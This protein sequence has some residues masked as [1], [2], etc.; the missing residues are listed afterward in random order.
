ML[1]MPAEKQEIDKEPWTGR[2]TEVRIG[3]ER[4]KDKSISQRRN[5]VTVSKCA[6]RSSN[7]R[8]GKYPLNPIV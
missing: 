6:E 5:W 1:G 2:E 7:M 4:P 8:S 3:S